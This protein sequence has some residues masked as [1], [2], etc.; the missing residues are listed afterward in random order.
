MCEAQG[1]HVD[2][3]PDG[4]DT[5]VMVHCS[6]IYQQKTAI[7]HPPFSGMFEITLLFWF[8]ADVLTFSV[9]ALLMGEG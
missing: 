7:L 1:C 2:I 9:L 4:R 5:S 6:P 3:S 8:R